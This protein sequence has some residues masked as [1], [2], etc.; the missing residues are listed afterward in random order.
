MSNINDNLDK[1]PKNKD[2][3]KSLRIKYQD[4]IQYCKK[5]LKNSKSSKEPYFVIYC[6]FGKLLSNISNDALT[7]YLYLGFNIDY[8]KGCLIKDE[9]KICKGTYF[10]K[11]K[12]NK[13]LNELESKNLIY[14]KK[15]DNADNCIFIIPY[16][17]DNKSNYSI[18]ELEEIY[19]TWIN[20]CKKSIE[21]FFILHKK[22]MEY[23][24]F[25]SP[26]AIKL[27]IYFGIYMD[28]KKGFF[29]RSLDTIA[30]NLNVSK[31]SISKWFKELEERNLIKRQQLFFN[32]SSCT[33][34]TPL[35][36]IDKHEFKNQLMFGKLKSQSLN[37]SSFQDSNI[38]SFCDISNENNQGF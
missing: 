6:S 9:D 34:M 16:D 38:D 5:N 23:W 20:T 11:D 32:S 17:L 10:R 21:P 24:C 27:Y 30:N 33:Y 14:I 22:F 15:D 19:T 7:L 4:Y 26:G 36:D 28:K 8:K 3:H 25:L 18:I 12:I 29:Y 31:R 2:I 37:N 13:C 35:I 1:E